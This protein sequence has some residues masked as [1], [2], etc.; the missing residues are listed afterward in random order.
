MDVKLILKHCSNNLLLGLIHNFTNKIQISSEVEHPEVE[1]SYSISSNPNKIIE[2]QDNIAAWMDTDTNLIWE[3]KTAENI[4]F[5]YSWNEKIKTAR[6]SVRYLMHDEKDI[7]AH[8]DKLNREKY[9]GFDDW[10]VPTI[11]ELQT[12]LIKEPTNGFY[13]KK[14][15]VKNSS[16]FYWS[17]TTSEDNKHSAFGIDITYAG[18]YNDNKGNGNYVRC[19]RNS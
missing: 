1:S 12:I 4:C 2:F 8:A 13:T 14:P 17:S 9:V 18:V 16:N 5:W 6:S 15:L 7:F 10:R 11:E 19:V 3:I